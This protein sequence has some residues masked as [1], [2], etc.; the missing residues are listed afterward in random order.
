ME[1]P[2]ARRLVC[3]AVC[4]TLVV[5]ATAGCSPSPRTEFI[6]DGDA[7]TQESLDDLLTGYDLSEV[8][9]ITTLDAPDVRQEMLADLRREGDEA[10]SVADLLTSGFPARTAAVPVFVEGAGYDGMEAWIIIE[11]WGD[12]GKTLA[13]R[14]IW[15]FDRSTGN[16]LWSMSRR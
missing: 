15:V 4:F 6:P 14:R 11:A 13:H 8:Q 7:Y 3:L 9:A 1:C 12:E 2:T 16:V 5:L 10:S